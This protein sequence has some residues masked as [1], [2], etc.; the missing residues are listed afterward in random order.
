VDIAFTRARLAIFVDGCFWHGCPEHATFPRSNAGWWS[1]KLATNRDR[2]IATTNHLTGLGWE[3]MRVWEHDDPDA[4]TVQIAARLA[5]SDGRLL[6]GQPPAR[7][8]GRD[9]S[10]SY[11]E[12]PRGPERECSAVVTPTGEQSGG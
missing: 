12:A 4:V 7:L 9:L 5:G 8:S 3:V 10:T 2:D 11:D 6:Q 1:A